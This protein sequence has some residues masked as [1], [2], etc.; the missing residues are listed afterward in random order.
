MADMGGMIQGG[1]PI[2]DGSM[3]KDWKIKMNAIFI[4]QDV[5]QVVEHGVSPP[6]AKAT[7]DDKKAYKIQHKLDGKARYLI[8]QYV[9]SPIFNR[10]SMAGTTK[11]AWDIL[12]ATYGAGDKHK[13]VKLLAL[14]RQFEFLIMEESDS[15]VGFLNKIQELVNDM[16]SCGDKVSEQHIVNKVLRSLPPRFDH[17]V[18]TIEE[19]KNLDALTF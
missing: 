4:F 6:G 13:K 1:L 11:E 17:L 10:I 19:T 8:Y 3:F 2:F 7:D 14:R 5:A 12:V 9:S 16:H 18:I 15:V